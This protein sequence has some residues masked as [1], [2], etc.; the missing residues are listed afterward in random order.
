MYKKIECKN[1]TVILYSDLGE[2]KAKINNLNLIRAAEIDNLLEQIN[3]EE[4]E[5]RNV[6]EERTITNRKKKINS[7]GLITFLIL[8]LFVPFIKSIINILAIY[9][10][11]FNIFVPILSA[12]IS[13]ILLQNLIFFIPYNKKDILSNKKVLEFLNQKHEDLVKEKEKL[14]K[15]PCFDTIRDHQ[16]FTI[17]DGKSIQTTIKYLNAIYK[18]EKKITNIFGE[19]ATIDEI[20]KKTFSGFNEEKVEYDSREDIINEIYKIIAKRKLLKKKTECNNAI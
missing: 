14:L 4:K 20:K 8:I 9:I 13:I 6:I 7:L 19:N 5:V 3:K 18:F 10:P 1:G 15:V 12:L 2:K 16:E 17:S 11:L